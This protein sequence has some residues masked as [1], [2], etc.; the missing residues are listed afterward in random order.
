[1]TEAG[2]ALL[3]PLSVVFAGAVGLRGWLYDRGWLP[4][5]R[6]S[7]PVISV[8]NLS[9]GGTGK[10][11]MVALVARTLVAAGA[12]PVIVSRG[13]GGTHR[14]GARAVCRDGGPRAD[15]AEV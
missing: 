14:A 7:V 2:A 11:P 8:G 9:V 3:T 6:L 12:K 4:S 13:H 1:M 10:S 5:R 15:A